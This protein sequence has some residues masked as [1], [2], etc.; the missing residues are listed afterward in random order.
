MLR[1][2]SVEMTGYKSGIKQRYFNHTEDTIRDHPEFIDSVLVACADLSLNFFRE[3][4]EDRPETLIMQSLFG[5]GA[6]AVILGAD[7]PDGVERPLFE[8]VTPRHGYPTQRTPPRGSSPKVAWWSGLLP[9]C[10]LYCGRSS[11][12]TWLR[13]WCRSA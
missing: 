12:S 13:R 6:A 5:D 4:R 11:S 1:N 9:R 8:L 2:N 3:A 10:R 7:G